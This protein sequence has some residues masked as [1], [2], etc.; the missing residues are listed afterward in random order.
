LEA[1]GKGD[2]CPWILIQLKKQQSLTKWRFV[3]LSS[4][5]ISVSAGTYLVVEWTIDL[6][7]FGSKLFGELLSHY[8]MKI[9]L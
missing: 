5:A 7:V 9:I 8:L 2:G 6:I 1:I 3:V 4:A